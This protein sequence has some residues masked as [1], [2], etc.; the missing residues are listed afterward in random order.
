M[1]GSIDTHFKMFVGFF[2][3]ISFNILKLSRYNWKGTEQIYYTTSTLIE[4]FNQ[5]VG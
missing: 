3:S 1:L 2:I 5:M 4:I